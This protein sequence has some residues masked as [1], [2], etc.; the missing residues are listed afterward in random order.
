MKPK[1]K[2][3][4]PN[5]RQSG[6]LGGPVLH[7]RALGDKESLTLEF[8]TSSLL[9]THQKLRGG[10]TPL[11]PVAVQKGRG[12]F[13]P[14]IRRFPKGCPLTAFDT[15]PDLPGDCRGSPPIRPGIG[16]RAKKR[17]RRK[18]QKTSPQNCVLTNRSGLPQ[19]GVLTN[20][21][22]RPQNAEG[23]GGPRG[24]RFGADPTRLQS[25]TTLHC[26]ATQ[27]SRLRVCRVPLR[28]GCTASV[29]TSRR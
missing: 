23:L 19:N 13:N 5:R 6:G 25:A 17:H 24:T 2:P 3:A 1:Q 22:G 16:K 4:R 11:F 7:R 12:H 27:V 18:Q 29:P 8:E 28:R 14:Q 26:Y 9:K 20:Q 15:A 21:S 10:S